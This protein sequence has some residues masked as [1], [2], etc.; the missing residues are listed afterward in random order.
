MSGSLEG[1][2][3]LGNGKCGCS[4]EQFWPHCPSGGRTPAAPPHLSL[5]VTNT[6]NT[7][8]LLISL[9]PLLSKFNPDR[10]VGRLILLCI[11]HWHEERKAGEITKLIKDSVATGRT[12][13][14]VIDEK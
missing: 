11:P 3:G 9:W 7:K 2:I 5:E 8:G 12:K 1:N 4:S 14:D 13:I 10:H 6:K